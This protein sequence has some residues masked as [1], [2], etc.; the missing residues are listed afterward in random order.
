[1]CLS[2]LSISPLDPATYQGRRFQAVYTTEGYFEIAPA[3]TG[4]SMVRRDF[5]QPEVR[6][7]SDSFFGDWLEAP[8]A[9]GAFCEDA[10]VGFVEGSP[11]R[12]NNRYR[13]SN[14]C[15]F[16]QQFRRVGLGG[17]LMQ[18]ILQDA[19]ASGARM[20]VLETQTCNLPAIFFYQRQ[21][22]S[23]IGF[24]LY[25]YSNEDP[26][27]HAVRIEMGLPLSGG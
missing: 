21:G 11:E 8:A 10:L 2:N 22:F 17:R 18:R 23:V 7:F 15:V 6:R 13:I 4:F 27:K 24:D 19:A 1:M 9:Y 16:S 20:A 26:A 5:P 14:L 3:E 12:W 25:A